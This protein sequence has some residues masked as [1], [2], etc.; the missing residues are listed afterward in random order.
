MKRIVLLI[1]AALFLISC[2]GTQVA[3]RT[4]SSRYE[5]GVWHRIKEGQTLW[6]ISKTYR[7]DL[8]ALKDANEIEDV[9][10]IAQGTWIFI[11]GA[12]KLL[13]VQGNVESSPEE[14][15]LDFVWPTSGEVVR[16]Y[17]KEKNDFNYGIDIDL[18][19]NE[20]IL[21]TQSGT[22]VLSGKIRGY[23][24]TLIIEH[25]N[26]FCSLY[27]KNLRI[28][29]KEGETV[30]R[31]QVVGKPESNGGS[32]QRIVH[33]ELFHEGKSINPLYYLP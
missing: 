24:P 19:G 25:D 17:G 6:R 13:Y 22:V 5:R 14:A 30:R 9:V 4:D 12:S 28:L 15:T 20:N 23:G 11:P 2:A 1:L 8:E 21:A 29:V 27:S 33:Y 10:H 32:A 3:Q 31:S 16:S 7:V 26:N 18:R